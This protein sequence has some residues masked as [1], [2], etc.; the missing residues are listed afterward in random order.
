MFTF[1]CYLATI[2]E[3]ILT[4]AEVVLAG[5]C[6]GDYLLSILSQ[7]C[8]QTRAEYYLCKNNKIAQKPRSPQPLEVSL[9]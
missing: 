4:V 3:Y 6:S 9:P 5:K 1:F 8:A 2:L 7:S